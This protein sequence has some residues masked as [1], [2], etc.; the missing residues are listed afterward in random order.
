MLA[1]Q[2]ARFVYQDMV[3]LSPSL[4]RI[5]PAD[6]DGTTPPPDGAPQPIVTDNDDGA[7]FPA[8]QIDFWNATM[9]WGAT[10]TISVTHEGVI[11]VAPFDQDVGCGGGRTCIPQPGT[12][13]QGRRA[14]E[15]PHV[16]RRIPQLRLLPGA[17]VGSHRRRGRA[18]GQPRGDPLVRAPQDDRQL[19]DPEP[20]HV[21]PVRRALPLDGL[22][23][24][25][26]GREPRRRLLDRKRHGAELSEHRVRGPARERRPE[27]ARPGRGDAARRHGLPDRHRPAAGATTR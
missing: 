25:G 15:P 22:G 13:G 26:Q 11:P 27:H 7:G 24:D 19:G 21:R 9:T 23:R 4:P 8:D 18:F 1:C 2:T 5:L 20:G 3:G 10:P 6:A 16:P 14:S 17:C 12:Y